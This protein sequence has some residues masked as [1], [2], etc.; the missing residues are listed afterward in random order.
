MKHFPPAVVLLVVGAITFAALYEHFVHA[1]QDLYLAAEFAGVQAAAVEGVL[2]PWRGLRDPAVRTLRESLWL[3]QAVPAVVALALGM[4]RSV[5]GRWRG[6]ALWGGL[7]VPLVPLLVVRVLLPGSP[8]T[9][10]GPVTNEPLAWAALYLEPFRV[11]APVFLGIYAGAAVRALG[12]M[13]AGAGGGR[14]SEA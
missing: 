6:V 4:L 1:W 3:T 7:L 11:A 9:S 12:R 13:L 2:E 8:L 10:F 5:R 14:R